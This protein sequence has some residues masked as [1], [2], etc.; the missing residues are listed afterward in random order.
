MSFR[1]FALLLLGGLFVPFCS[2]AAVAVDSG[3]VVD[4]LSDGGKSD[5]VVVLF[6][7]GTECPISNRYAPVINA[8]VDAFSSDRRRFFAVYADATVTPAQIRAHRQSYRYTLPALIDAD[9][10]LARK[11]GARVTPEVLV[12]RVD[13]KEAGGFRTLYRGRIDDRYIAFG[14]ARPAPTREDL[15][16]VLEELAAGRIPRPRTTQA[17]GCYLPVP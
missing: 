10:Q 17:V 6:F 13:K 2:Q 12:C 9:F 14:R 16:E 4:P 7:L 1:V 3:Q 11:T 8:L 15:R 5:D